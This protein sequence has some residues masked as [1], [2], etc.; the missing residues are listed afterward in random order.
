LH[1]ETLHALADSDALDNACV[2][3]AT[4]KTVSTLAAFKVR[5]PGASVGTYTL[6]CHLR[7]WMCFILIRFSASKHAMVMAIERFD[8]RWNILD[9]IKFA[10]RIN[11]TPIS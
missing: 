3:N 6:R 9:M 7:D 1:S 8:S 10:A 5:G 4:S 11:V 2:A